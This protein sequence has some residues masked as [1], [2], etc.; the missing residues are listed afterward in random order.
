MLRS[1]LRRRA[2]GSAFFRILAIMLLTIT[3]TMPQAT[4]LGYLL[5]KHPGRVQRFALS[6]GEAHV[7][8]PESTDERTTA[9]LLLDLDPISLVRGKTGG[10]SPLAQYVNDK[11]YI[12][13]SFLSGAISKAQNPKPL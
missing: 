8:Y 5:H 10:E 11:P 1:E 7:F 9:A 6:Y 3:T 12:A 13:S 2:R 4:D